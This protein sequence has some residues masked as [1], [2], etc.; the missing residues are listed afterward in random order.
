[1]SAIF[2][3]I[4]QCI[5]KASSV[6]VVSH[7]RPDG[8]AIGSA[9][10]MG[11]LLEKLGKTVRVVNS[12]LVP[13]RLEFLPR[14][15]MVSRPSV[16]F[17]VDLVIA[18]D[19][20]G[21]DRIGEAVWAMAE[22]AG[23]LINIDH[24]ISNTE[25]GDLNYV[26]SESPATGQIVFQLARANGWEMDSAIAENLYVAISTDTG[27]FCY[28]S[29]TADTYRIAA[30]LIELGVDVGELNRKLYSSYPKRRVE[31]M[32]YLL[33]GMSLDCDGRF[34]SVSLP[35]EVASQFG[36]QPGDMEGMIDMI[37]GI[38]S[39]ILAAFFEELPGGKIRVSSRSKDAQFSVS[40]LC[41]TFGGGGHTLAAGARL[42]GPMDEARKRVLDQ[43]CVMLEA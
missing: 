21:R 17:D 14:R 36:I 4:Q 27:S 25:Y 43:V 32:G 39:V 38:D 33:E 35:L 22:G 31:L 24:H 41:A 9:V 30:E 34:A 15:E 19:S 2:E 23:V 7:D 42:A 1:M 16:P 11:I 18:L 10:A 13:E 28:P 20:A 12:D 26:D 8:D 37:R 3:E 6:L 40:E 29:T 5:E